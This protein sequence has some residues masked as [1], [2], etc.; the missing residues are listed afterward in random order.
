VRFREKRDGRAL[1]AVFDA[2][3]RELLAVAAHLVPTA[4]QAEDV[5]Q[6]T[7]QRALEHAERYDS[8]Q[9]LKGWLYGILWREAARLTRVERRVPPPG[10]LEAAPPRAPDEEAAERELPEAVRHALARLPSPYREVV[11]PA[12]FRD[13]SARE[14][15]ARLARSPGTVR[16]QLQRGLERLRRELP[17][18][19]RELAGRRAFGL[20]GLAGLRERVLAHAGVVPAAVPAAT[21]AFLLTQLVSVALPSAAWAAAG[22]LAVAGSLGVAHVLGSKP[23]PEQVID[24]A[25]VRASEPEPDAE[26]L[27]AAPEAAAPVADATAAPRTERE[28]RPAARRRP[29]PVA[30]PQVLGIVVDEERRP[31]A[32]VTVLAEAENHY[33]YAETLTSDDGRFAFGDLAAGRWFVHADD[34]RFARM[35]WQTHGVEI[36]D[37][38]GEAP[39]PELELVLGRRHDVPGN[40]VDEVGAPVPGTTVT[41]V[42]HWPPGAEFPLQGHLTQE[43]ASA[44]TDEHGAFG[45]E[46]LAAGQWVARLDHPDCARTLA[47][48]EV[49]GPPPRLAIDGGTP[50][51]G[52]VLAGGAPLAG[53]RVAVR[54]TRQSHLTMGDWDV[55]TDAAGGFRVARIAPVGESRLHGVPTLTVSVDDDAWRSDHHRLYESAAGTLPRVVLE[56]FAR[57]ER[58]PEARDVGRDW[59]GEARRSGKPF[60]SGVIRVRLAD[61]AAEDV[62]VWLGGLSPGLTS[63]FENGT[64]ARG[65][66]HAFERLAAGR[67]RVWTLNRAGANF[68]PALLELGPGETAEVELRP[69]ALTLSGALTCAGRPVR[70]GSLTARSI[71][72]ELG[73]RATGRIAQ[74]RY[75]LADLA[76]GS[77]ELSIGGD[78]AMT[79]RFEARVG[80]GDTILDLELPAGRI[81]GRLGFERTPE[82]DELEVSVFPYGWY[83]ESGNRG[84]FVAPDAEGRFAARHLPPGDYVVSA[85]RAQRPVRSVVVSIGAADSPREVV[86][87]REDAAGVLCGIVTGSGAAGKLG[88]SI[89]A[90]K[91]EPQGLRR[92]GFAELDGS[93]R[94]RE[95][96]E[97]GRYDLLVSDFDARAPF[98]LIPDVRVEPGAE[99]PLVITLPAAR[100]VSIALDAGGAWTPCSTWSL[101]L[102][103]AWLP[104]VYFVGSEPEGRRASAR[105]FQLPFGTYSVAA[106]FGDPAP[107]VREFTVVPGEGTQ[108]IIVTRP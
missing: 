38:P 106:D 2:T 66:S 3:A 42:R 45:F 31:L 7:F 37:E 14:I 59:E 21:A 64:I 82:E 65:E 83:P 26:P 33:G 46:R 12:L 47:E 29:P 15:A 8:A 100:A 30:D 54:S 104:F 76:G 91:R 49:P 63:F 61:D 97:P 50:L 58:E 35:W 80:P 85:S 68:T 17:G 88:G 40:V 5:V 56:A 102:R 23:L 62:G 95:E 93:G 70:S 92:V 94:F 51:D 90:L 86:L 72:D 36:A 79:Q 107:V 27:R 10:T 48:F 34:E 89:A 19:Q 25:Q 16:V 32:G 77:Y 74:G 105:P 52:L 11:E 39:L 55:T 28:A 71:R 81:E 20:V 99:T 9:S 73:Q 24:L 41:L 78:G 108:E 18:A 44:T 60:G 53:V 67:Y 4:D 43:L 1:A 75:E 57:G 6:S 22:T 101:R 87:L 69:G 84:V 13:E 98:L 96:L 103:E